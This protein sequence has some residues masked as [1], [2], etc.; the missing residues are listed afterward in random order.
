MLAFSLIT[1]YSSFGNE[2][3][4]SIINIFAG[5]RST[6]KVYLF[7]AFIIG[8][9]LIALLPLNRLR[10]R[11]S[12]IISSVITALSYGFFLLLFFY[13]QIGTGIW[14]FVATFNN[15]EI[16][17]TTL[18]HNHLMKGVVG[19]LLRSQDSA[20][21][22]KVD[23]GM[24]YINII[25]D[26]LLWIGALLAATSIIFLVI[27]FKEIFNEQVKWPIVFVILYS[28]ISFSL[29]KNIF[30]GGIL[31]KETPVALSALLFILY[32]LSQKTRKWDVANIL[33]RISPI[34]L[35]LLV[36]LFFWWQKFILLS[37]LKYNL[38]QVIFFGTLIVTMLYAHHKQKIDRLLI[39]LSILSLTFLYIP[40][41]NTINNYL[42]NNTKFSNKETYI[43]LLSNEAHP[44]F[45]L[46]DKIGDL[47][48]YEFSPSQPIT[49]ASLYDKYQLLDNITPVTVPWENCLP[50]SFPSEAKFT[51]IS[52][53]VIDIT[54]T[55]SHHFGNLNKIVQ[56]DR[57]N[58]NY[59]YDVTAHINNCAP[60]QL[61]IIEHLVKERGGKTFFMLNLE[62]FNVGN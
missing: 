28:I 13:H 54:R 43:G 3:F 34:I 12:F 62:E 58:G 45:R 51:L 24:A 48:M 22:E 60:R 33:L 55:T 9:C 35:Y 17:T 56:L 42:A 16:S 23:T 4:H 40:I 1:Y 41:S 8:L 32:L 57:K 49:M 6:V 36:M 46:V 59:Q 11:N 19:L 30:D 26:P 38:F 53:E 44:T 10:V 27:K 20:V 18:N 50:S 61:N 2:I 52:K 5:G 37:E 15:S 47:K 25:P 14:V 21:Q 29:V 39:L 31:N 7:F